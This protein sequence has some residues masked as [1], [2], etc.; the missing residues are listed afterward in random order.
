MSNRYK[1]VTTATRHHKLRSG[2]AILG[3]QPIYSSLPPQQAV[4]KGSLGSSTRISELKLLTGTCA[5]CRTWLCARQVLYRTCRRADDSY[6]KPTEAT[7]GHYSASCEDPLV[8]RLDLS[9]ASHLSFQQ[10]LST[11]SL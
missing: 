5:A 7:I 6:E 1:G 8:G 4:E 9:H 10:A 11:I 3:P 2:A